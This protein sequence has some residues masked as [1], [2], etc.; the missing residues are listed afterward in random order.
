MVVTGTPGAGKTTVSKVMAKRLSGVHVDTTSMALREDLTKG[1][2]AANQSY[3]IDSE[4]LS[5]RLSRIIKLSICD[6]VVEGHFIPR[7]DGPEPS[8]IYVL[9]CHPKI[10]MLR[11]KRKGYSERKIADNVAAELLDLCL[12]DV[13]STFGPSKIVEIDTS[14]KKPSQVA[15]LALKILDGKVRF[16]DV[17]VDWLHRLQVE[18]TLQE[19]LHYVESYTPVIV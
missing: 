17:R 9:R 13:A 15:S 18:G 1:Y 16:K 4:R 8:V 14:K 2:D 10:L 12:H 5:R 11:L 3:I 7:I 6:V 19:I